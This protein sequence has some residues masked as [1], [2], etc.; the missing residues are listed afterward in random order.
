MVHWS[1]NRLVRAL[2]KAG[3]KLH[4]A[5][6]LGAAPRNGSSPVRHQAPM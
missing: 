2:F 6:Q 1:G 5:A 3:P 4:Q